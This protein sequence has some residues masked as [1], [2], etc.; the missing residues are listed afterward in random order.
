MSILTASNLSKEFG[1]DEIFS[2]V[3]V[4]IPHKARIA[5]V[6]PNGAG[7]TTLLYLL[8]GHDQPTQGAVAR[9][10]GVRIGFLPQRAEFDSEETLYDELLTAFADLR[11][12]EQEIRDLE[13]QMS[14]DAQVSADAMARY[15]ELQAEFERLDGYTYETRIKMVL[16]G[17]GFRPEQYTQRL[18]TFSGGQKTRALLARLLLTAPDLLVLDEPTN[19]LDIDAVEW[20]ENFLKDFGGAVLIVSHDRYFM[21]HVVNTIWELDFGEVATYRGNYS[22]YLRQRGERY[23]RLQKEYEAQQAM[24]AKE[25]EYIRRNIAGQ[26]TRQAQGRRTRLER[27]TKEPER[28]GLVKRP[29]NRET[30]K[31]RL[32]SSG[33]SGDRVLYTKRLHVGYPDKPLF[34]APDIVLL[35]GETAALI[36]PNGVGKSTLLKT[37]MG[38]LNALSGEAMLG[39]NVKV[40]YFAQAHELLNPK[41]TLLDE[42]M[43]VKNMTPGEARGSLAQFMF[44]GDEVYR[45]VSTLSGGERG[46]LALAKLALA[47]ANFLLLDEPTNHLDIP[48]QEIL[49]DVL[50]QFEGTIL[51]VTHDR[52]LVDALATQIWEARAGKL[53]VFN[54]PYTEFVAAK[55][56]AVAPPPPASNGGKGA[57]AAA[58]NAKK[59]GLNAYQL[60]KRVAEVEAQIAALEV[61]VNRLHDQIG[62]A[63][64]QGESAKV[65][66]LAAQYAQAQHDL[67]AALATWETLMS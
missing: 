3:T 59:H 47:G 33:R 9:A 66:H 38:E 41:N 46:R 18:N 20:L 52:Y 36:G 53:T 35:R 44:R 16:Q 32:A 57:G 55:N 1:T 28:Y 49:Q 7:K 10:R 63:S 60:Q 58:A 30:M 39:A 65:T 24:I 48:S 17:V 45:E 62:A 14:S 4:E 43:R 12:M 23:E 51:L 40:G 6:G 25:E 13:T 21:D 61:Q 26:N 19:H 67:D 31:L 15:G 11:R 54:G 8:M 37:L 27:L 50:N 2:G 34:D 29:A 22:A 64:A 56:K 42:L 5:L